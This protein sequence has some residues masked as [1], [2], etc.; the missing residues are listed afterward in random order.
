M[1]KNAE[2]PLFSVKEEQERAVDK[3]SAL[4]ESLLSVVSR[5]RS[6]VEDVRGQTGC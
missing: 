3:R 6:G 2:R 5:R 1:D 4:R